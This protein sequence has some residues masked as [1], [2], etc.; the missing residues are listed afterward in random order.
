M[1]KKQQ[2]KTKTKREYNRVISKED[3]YFEFLNNSVNYGSL[4]DLYRKFYFPKLLVNN[5][6]TTKK[7]DDIMIS[8][9]FYDLARGFIKRRNADLKIKQEKLLEEQAKQEAKRTRD[10]ELKNDF[11]NPTPYLE[12]F[13][14][15]RDI[16]DY[17]IRR[18]SLKI[19]NALNKM[20]L[21][22]QRI[23][24]GEVIEDIDKEMPIVTLNDGELSQMQA[25]KALFETARTTMKLPLRYNAN[26]EDDG[27]KGSI[28]DLLGAISEYSKQGGK[29]VDQ[30]GKDVPLVNVNF[31]RHAK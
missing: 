20:K 22:Q 1:K 25:Y 27:A 15:T 6:T 14:M 9:N 3:L 18:V 8:R 19:A 31:E 12:Q 10:I 23:L 17:G 28:G 24:N 26:I 4:A 7:I 5:K 16:V 11:L 21:L 2:I 30:N 29:I 13:K